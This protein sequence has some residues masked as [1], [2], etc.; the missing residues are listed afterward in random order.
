VAAIIVS[1]QLSLSF[2]RPDTVQYNDTLFSLYPEMLDSFHSRDY[3]IYELDHHV[4]IIYVALVRIT[5]LSTL[6]RL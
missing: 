5:L 6:G 2:L 1:M 3:K 4:D